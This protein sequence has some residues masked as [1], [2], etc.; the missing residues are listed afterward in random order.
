MSGSGRK[1]QI[2]TIHAKI[3]NRRKDRLHKESTALVKDNE[4]I[5]IGNLSASRLAKTPMAKSVLDAGWWMLKTLLCYKAI[6]RK[7]VFVEVSEAGTTRTCCRCGAS[8]G[9][10]GREGLGVREWMCGACGAVH[11]RD[12]NAA[13]NILRLGHQSLRSEVA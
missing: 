2:R 3:R 4:L 8:G 11:D 13:L 6:A 1:R 5:V 9:P 7:V 12:V 10:Q